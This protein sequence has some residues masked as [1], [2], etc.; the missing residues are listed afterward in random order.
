[1]DTTLGIRQIPRIYLMAGRNLGARGHRV[2]F[3]VLVPAGLP[4]LVAGPKLGWAFAWRPLISAEM[5]FVSL[6]LG[7]FLMVGRDLN[8]MSQVIAVMLL[9]MAVG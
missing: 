7:Q 6:G 2:F 9:I 1:M 3:H 4:H 8:D 5:I